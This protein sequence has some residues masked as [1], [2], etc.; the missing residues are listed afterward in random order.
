MWVEERGQ[1]EGRDDRRGWTISL[2]QIRRAL[3]AVYFL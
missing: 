2:D 3:T 1:S